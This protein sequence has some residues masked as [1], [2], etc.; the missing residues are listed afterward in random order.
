[1][2]TNITREALLSLLRQFAEQRPG[3]EFGNYGDVSAYRAEQRSITR[4]LHHARTLLRQV[5]LRFSISADDIV[6][7]MQHAYGGR[8][9]LAFDKEGAPYLD[10]TTGHYWP[11]EFR[12]A[13][14]AVMADLLW[15]YTKAGWPNLDG[16]GLRKHLRRE[17]GASIAN[18]W[19]R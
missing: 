10:Y 14:C 2:S 9:S 18:R 15:N 19:F 12:R 16:N 11:T 8:L 5:E 7:A 1:M 13:V 4:D 6:N 17:F 3:L